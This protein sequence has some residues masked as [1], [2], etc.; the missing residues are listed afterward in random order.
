[1]IPPSD[2]S[3]GLAARLRD[4][5]RN[6]GAT[7]VYVSGAPSGSHLD[8]LTDRRLASQTAGGEEGFA[9]LIAEAKRLGMHVVVD[10]DHRVS[11]ASHA[12]RYRPLVAFRMDP[13]R[14][15]PVPIEGSVPTRFVDVLRLSWAFLLCLLV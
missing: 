11:A 7:V 5:Q 6:T 3:A 12:R 14:R 2:P 15:F 8:E 13:S 1:L 10:A 4:V 9:E